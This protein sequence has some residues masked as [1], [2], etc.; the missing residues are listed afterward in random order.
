MP[1]SWI[2]VQRLR[3]RR[4]Q[5]LIVT[6]RSRLYPGPLQI[7]S[8]H[9]SGVRTPDAIDKESP[10]AILNEKD[11]STPWFSSSSTRQ[12]VPEMVL[13]TLVTA[14][15]NG[16]PH[17]VQQ[18]L[19]Q[20]ADING[21]SHYATPLE[22]AILGGHEPTVRLLLDRGEH[23]D[24]PEEDNM[25][26]LGVVAQMGHEST[27]RWLLDRG[28]IVRRLDLIS[29]DDREWRSCTPLEAAFE[30]GDKSTVC[31]PPGHGTAAGDK[32]SVLAGTTSLFVSLS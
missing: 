25:S 16:K 10:Q 22:G 11:T 9:Q 3:T 4:N 12:A 19:D 30:V 29:P 17:T 28:M 7:T 1:K 24:G 6:S 15:C 23:V 31:L 18:V 21:R 2:A 20:G 32:H 14:A 13:P 26:P 8:C 5:G 27:V